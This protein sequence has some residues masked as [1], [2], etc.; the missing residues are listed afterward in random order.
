[1][2]LIVNGIDL[3]QIKVLN[4]SHDDREAANKEFCIMEL[5]N[6]V[7]GQHI[8]RTHT[9]S[10]PCVAGPLTS[11]MINWNDSASNKARQT[12][13]PLIPKLIGTRPLNKYNLPLRSKDYAVAEK[14]DEMAAFELVPWLLEN[15]FLDT[16]NNK[17]LTQSKINELK[18]LKNVKRKRSLEVKLL[19]ESLPLSAPRSTMISEKRATDSGLD[20]I[21]GAASYSYGIDVVSDKIDI[22]PSK[23]N[24]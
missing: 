3:D 12:L 19:M 21:L 22:P 16:K 11:L 7:A 8:A 20:A 17:K 15:F 2:A 13:K 18:S 1:M 10:P 14:L 24:Y 23:K 9:D 4:G 6:Y 5:A